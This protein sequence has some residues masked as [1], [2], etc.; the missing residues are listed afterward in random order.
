MG[1]IDQLYSQAK[2][3]SFVLHLVRAYAPVS[4]IQKYWGDSSKKENL[5]CCL[6]GHP[7]ASIEEVWGKTIATEGVMEEQMKYSMDAILNPEAHKDD[8]R[9]DVPIVKAIDGKIQ[10]FTGDNTETVMCLACAKELIEFTT[11][12]IWRGD[13]QINFAIKKEIAKEFPEVVSTIENIQQKQKEDYDNRKKEK[14]IKPVQKIQSGNAL[15]DFM[16]ERT[17]KKLGLI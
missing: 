14:F 9:E 4:K 15:G 11:N 12:M 13:K 2:S 8:K 7:L 1:K 6:C 3:R 5:K 17:K 10:A 16:D